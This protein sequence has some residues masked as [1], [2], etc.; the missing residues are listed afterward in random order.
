M[1]ERTGVIA[2][3]IFRNEENGYTVA[4]MET[5]D[6]YFTI[7]GNLP[8]V[9]KGSHFKLVG[10][11][12]DHKVYGEQFSFTECQEVMPTGKEAIFD[13]LSSGL[14]K[15]VG[16]STARAIVS[17]FG[18]NT[19]E[20]IENEPMR[21]LE[22]SGIGE[23]TA[24]K[25]AD[26]FYEYIQF[27]KIALEL[28]SYGIS[29][30]V[31]FR[32]YSVYEANT[33]NYIL[34]NPYRLVDEV[35]GFGFIKA[36]RIA[37]KI[38]I[39]R[40]SEFRVKSG[41]KYTLFWFMGDGNTYL[42]RTVLA[43][44]TAELLNVSIEEVEEG[45][46]RLA[47]DGDIKVNSLD[48][49][50]ICYLFY[51]FQAEKETT[52]NIRR[53]MHSALKPLTADVE[54][55]IRQAEVESEIELS[56]KQKRAVRNS[57]ASG[58]SVIT[59]GPGTGKTTIIDSIMRILDRNGFETA[60]CAPTGR[61]AKRITESSGR[62]AQT[63]HRLLEYT[64]D[65]M[66]KR[67]I[68]GRD[69]RN[70]LKYDVVLVDEASMVDIQLMHALT[71][72]MEDGTRLILIGDSDQLP[73]VGPGN[74]LRDIIDSEFTEVTR[75]TEIFRQAEES[76]IVVNAHRINNGEYP[77]FNVKDRDF[78]F[79]DR[80]REEDARNLLVELVS[81]RLPKYYE[82]DNILNDIQVITPTRKGL[83]GTVQLNPVLQEALNPA[84]PGKKEKRI[85]DTL[86]REGD[87]V[88]QIRNNY[89][90]E[91]LKHEDM[92]D[93]SGV[94]NGDIGFIHTIDK[95]NGRVVVVFDDDKF[96]VYDNTMMDQLELAYALT[97]HKSQGS[98]F[99]IV[100]MPVPKVNTLLATR[101]LLY[102]AV[103]RG[104]ETV[105]LLGREEYVKAMVDNNRSRDRYSGLKARL[106]ELLE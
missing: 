98:E 29:A 48:G 76:L 85:G 70:P 99:P 22:V 93:G 37:E 6:E 72:A 57:I 55:M 101:N 25:I 8:R 64:Y 3:I 61:A 17:K 43:E 50:E 96:V 39:P 80:R 86:F 27:A 2:D 40:D 83:L 106:M 81:D 12:V 32:L 45:I 10:K 35:P 67:M 49:E 71:D 19:L 92:S 58:V 1:E 44:K 53:L 103:T 75:L 95:E 47:M 78:Y 38:G 68:F 7:V 102:T 13:F 52:E 11:F 79:M 14:I 24:A 97:V 105:V 104:K 9:S 31:A 16:P 59:G 30:I 73:S 69:R 28:Q 4:V 88:M 90:I 87:K 54:N 82:V 23:K 42:P 33:L 56:E 21:L 84:S 34:E 66:G 5:E 65:E 15:G 51:L 41:I 18:E 89:N 46:L 62:F 91:W 36:D 77:E 94:F 100:V 74:V 26:S 63:I 60:I 20:I